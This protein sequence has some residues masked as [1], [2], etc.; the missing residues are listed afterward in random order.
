MEPADA[1]LEIVDVDR[2]WIVVT[3]PPD[4]IERMIGERHFRQTVCLLHDQLKLALF[5]V[6]FE[7]LGTTDVALR[8]GTGFGQLSELIPVTSRSSHITCALDDEQRAPFR[9]EAVTV[10]DAVRNDQIIAGIEDN[11]A[12]G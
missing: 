7:I 4:H 2:P 11:T 12:K 5:I 1:R 8:V 10:K 6:S 9:R 3:I